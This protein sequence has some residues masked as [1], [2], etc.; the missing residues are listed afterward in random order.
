MARMRLFAAEAL[1]GMLAPM[2]QLVIGVLVLVFVVVC[3][4]RLLQRGPSRMN[5]AVVVMGAAIAG[6][7]ILGVLFA[8]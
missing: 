2:W 3:T 7:V 6:V 4:Y 8:H 5:H 1:L